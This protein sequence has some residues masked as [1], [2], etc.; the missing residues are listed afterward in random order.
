M[1]AGL[2]DHIR[3]LGELMVAV[4]SAEPSDN[5]VAKPPPRSPRASCLTDA[6]PYASYR[7]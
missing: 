5:P 4:L 7:A 6:A 3:T 1:A 2:T